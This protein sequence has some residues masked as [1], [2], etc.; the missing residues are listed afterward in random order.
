MAIELLQDETRR[1]M[2]RVRAGGA[3]DEEAKH[4][5]FRRDEQD[6]LTREIDDDTYH[7]NLM[8]GVCYAMRPVWW[9][10]RKVP[11]NGGGEK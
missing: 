6:R 10:A 3:F 5:V 4:T 9:F 7:P 1:G 8:D 11:A 2:L